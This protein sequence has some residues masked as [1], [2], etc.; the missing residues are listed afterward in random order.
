[1]SLTT[2]TSQEFTQI[3]NLLEQRRKLTSEIAR[4][5]A[6]LE[7]LNASNVSPARVVKAKHRKPGKRV[8]TKEAVLQLLASAGAK[9]LTV[10][11]IAKVTGRPQGSLSVWF[12]TGAKKIKGLQRVAPGRFAYKG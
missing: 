1:M 11:E 2:L 5:D 4:I 12:Y 9:G 10:P 7:S 8:T 6:Q 3:V